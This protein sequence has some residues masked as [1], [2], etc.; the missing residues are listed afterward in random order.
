MS[1]YSIIAN[2]PYANFSDFFE[3]TD[4]LHK[5]IIL[6]DGAANHFEGFDILP[7][8]IIGDMDSINESSKNYFRS[9]GV[10][11]IEIVDQDTTDLEKAIVLCKEDESLKTINI[12]NALGG[13]LD[14]SMLNLRLL[15]K[16]YSSRYEIIL[17]SK[18]EKVIFLRDCHIVLKGKRNDRVALLS[19]THATITSNGLLYEMDG[20]KLEFAV[21]ESTSNFLNN[22]SAALSIKGDALLIV[23]K[24]I[25]YFR[26][27]LTTTD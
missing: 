9:K 22:E 14:H 12:Y 25:E 19:F 5:N 8:S 3:N 7:T 11:I 21:N 16:H 23:D 6:L 17:F 1:C 10:C 18:S 13:R 15:K 20:Y 2:S 27:C 24:N 26:R 4:L